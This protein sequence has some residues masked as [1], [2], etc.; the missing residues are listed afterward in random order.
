MR[1]STGRAAPQRQVGRRQLGGCGERPRHDAP[2]AAAAALAG[3]LGD[4]AAGVVHARVRAQDGEDAVDVVEDRGGE[5]AGRPQLARRVARLH[6]VHG[7]GHQGARLRQVHPETPRLFAQQ[8]QVVLAR[9]HQ[10]AQ[11]RGQVAALRGFHAFAREQDDAH[12]G[13]APLEVADGHLVEI[14]AREQQDGSQH[15]VAADHRVDAAGL[16]LG[17]VGHDG[18]PSLAA[19]RQGLRQRAAAVAIGRVERRTGARV[20]RV[21]AAAHD[22]GRFVEHDD[23]APHQFGD[24]LAQVVERRAPRQQRGHLLVR[25][26]GALDALHVAFELRAR[27]LCARQRRVRLFE[28]HRVLD[29]DRGVR[30]QG[31]QDGDVLRGVRAVVAVGDEQQADH[32]V[33]PQH[34]D[35]GH[36]RDALVAEGRV[37]LLVVGKAPVAQVVRRREGQARRHDDAHDAEVAPGHHVAG[38]LRQRAVGGQHV[39]RA[40][41]GVVRRQ[42]GDLRAEQPAR[43]RHHGVQQFVQVQPAGE[44]AGGL[45]HRQHAA[46]ALLPQ[47]QAVAHGHA[48][49]DALREAR[50]RRVVGRQ[51]LHLREQRREVLR[52][53]T[54]VQQVDE[55]R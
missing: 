38:A 49:A 18:P 36:R 30:G 37:Q 21:G 5:Q 40:E 19:A 55:L 39:E 2:V 7:H 31:A 29:G 15:V 32:L 41:V 34:G 53:R 4:R 17:L 9:R 3:E 22:L 12:D 24:G 52:R 43:A 46:F 48:H 27:G 42:P 25:R 45:D 47:V 1:A 28:R 23:A 6:V 33:L 10:G 16:A 8:R 44:V 26:R 20:G 54:L 35:A 51:F 50:L 14:A 13:R 11:Q